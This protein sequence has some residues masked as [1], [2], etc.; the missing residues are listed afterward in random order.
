MIMARRSFTFTIIYE[1]DEETGQVCAS[2][3][4]LDLGSYGPTLNDA[5]KRIREAL[6][7]HLEGMLEE[8]IPIPPDILKSEQLTIDVSGAAAEVS[9]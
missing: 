8:D 6:A 2:V 9:A 1:R 5:R 7:L 4:A 3:P